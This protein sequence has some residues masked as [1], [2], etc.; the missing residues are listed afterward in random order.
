VRKLKFPDSFNLNQL[1]NTNHTLI[2]ESSIWLLLRK[3]FGNLANIQCK[4]TGEASQEAKPPLNPSTWQ[5]NQLEVGHQLGN[6]SLDFSL[7]GQV[8]TRNY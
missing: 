1:A 5:T 8:R 4:L 6:L 7:E 2:M 3:K